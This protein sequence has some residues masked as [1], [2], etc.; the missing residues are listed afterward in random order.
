[1]QVYSIPISRPLKRAITGCWDAVLLGASLVFAYGLSGAAFFQQEQ[2]T[3]IFLSVAL[4]LSLLAFIRVGLYRVLVLYMG[5]QSSLLIAQCVTIATFILAVA[6]SLSSA[7]GEARLAILP[8]FWMLALLLMGG[9]RRS[10]E[11]TSELQSHG[12]SR[13]PSSA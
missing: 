4:I 13:M 12:E 7:Q 3:L 10:E 2:K 11:R 5:L 8:I 9:S 6:Y 1:M